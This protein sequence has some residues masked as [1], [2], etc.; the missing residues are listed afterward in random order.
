M[1]ATRHNGRSGKHGSYNPKH[2]DRNFDVKHSEHIDVNMAMQNV[3]WDCYSG[4]RIATQ[5]GEYESFDIIE[6]RF[7]EENYS[8]FVIGQNQRNEMNRHTERN[9]TVEDIY[10][11]KKTCP[12]ESIYQ[13]GNIDASVDSKMLLQITEAFLEWFDD[14]FGEHIHILDWALHVDEATPHI[15]ERHVFDAPNRYGEIAPQ[16]DKA[17]VDAWNKLDEMA[18]NANDRSRDVAEQVLRHAGRRR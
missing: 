11:D 4:K 18:T 2:N 17:Q 16:Q 5:T 6:Y 1:K 13:L 10:R 7:Y 3:Y 8:D 15:H 14:E 12:E 9:R